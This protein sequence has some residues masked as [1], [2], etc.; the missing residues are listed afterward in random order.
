MRLGREENRERPQN[1]TKESLCLEEGKTYIFLMS[2]S[3]ETSP[4]K[5]LVK[6]KMKLV[7]CYKHHAVFESKKGIRQSYRYWDIEK[8]LLGQ[9]R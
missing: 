8:L 1:P 5:K 2:E 3:E 6:K 7:K 9:S 4:K